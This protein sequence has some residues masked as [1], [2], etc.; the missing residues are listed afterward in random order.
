MSV[1]N[2]LNVKFLGN[3]GRDWFQVEWFDGDMTAVDVFGLTD[4]FTL[5]DEKGYPRENAWFSKGIK[6]A[7]LEKHYAK[8]IKW[9]LG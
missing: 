2:V 9:L 1:V 7:I 4:D 3:D 6:D 8:Q 5:L